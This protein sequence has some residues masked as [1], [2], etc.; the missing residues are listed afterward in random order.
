M[1]QRM[2]AWIQ[3]GTARLR[4]AWTRGRD[5]RG[6]DE[7]VTLVMKIGLVLLFA[8]AAFTWLKGPG[9]TWLNNTFGSVTQY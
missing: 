2:V 4:A 8:A 5:D 1:G 9:L 7:W 6:V 3:I